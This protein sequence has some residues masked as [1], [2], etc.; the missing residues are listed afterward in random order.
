MHEHTRM[1]EERLSETFDT[2]VVNQGTLTDEMLAGV[3]GV[4]VHTVRRYVREL[5]QRGNPFIKSN[6]V[7]W[8]ADGVEDQRFLDSYRRNCRYL[9]TKSV[10]EV[11]KLLG[12]IASTPG[13]P[14][15]KMKARS[16]LAQFEAAAASAEMALELMGEE[17]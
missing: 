12:T 2:L 14:K 6:G 16:A 10:T 1:K 17:G 11:G 9:V 8:T 7:W 4:H 13:N 3:I 15:S 5:Q